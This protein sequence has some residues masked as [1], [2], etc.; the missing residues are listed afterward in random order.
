MLQ[1][2]PMERR[3]EVAARLREGY[4]EIRTQEKVEEFNVKRAKQQNVNVIKLPQCVHIPANL[5]GRHTY[6]SFRR[7]TAIREV[8]L[9]LE[10]RG[11]RAEDVSTLGINKLILILKE[12]CQGLRA[13]G[14]LI[15][16]VVPKTSEPLPDQQVNGDDK[17][18]LDAYE[19][20]APWPG[21][22]GCLMDY[23]LYCRVVLK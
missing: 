21:S 4:L 16:L 18:F 6:S 2:V 10:A 13:D 19:H 11:F 15:S 5:A 7:V 20:G 23:H 1:Q 17:T 14:D 8:R 3:K 9:E 22:P 12:H